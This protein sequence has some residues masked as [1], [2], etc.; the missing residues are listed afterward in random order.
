MQTHLPLASSIVLE[1]MQRVQLIE[2][3]HTAHSGK[4]W[5]HVVDDEV[6]APDG[7]EFEGHEQP[8]VDGVAGATRQVSHIVRELHLEH[9]DEHGRHEYAPV[10][11]TDR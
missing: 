3:T 7:K 10:E 5:P 4:H 8:D 1:A 11:S 9:S 2:S 6:M